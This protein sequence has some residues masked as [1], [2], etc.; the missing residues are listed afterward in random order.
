[1]EEFSRMQEKYQQL[2]QEAKDAM[3]NMRQFRQQAEVKSKEVE[4]C[5]KKLGQLERD[6]QMNSLTLA[7]L[8]ANEKEQERKLL[9]ARN[10]IGL[11]PVDRHKW[12]GTPRS[13]AQTRLMIM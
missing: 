4:E 6:S 5:Q 11:V 3:S 7:S 1:M 12:C 10:E 8:E 9:E 13:S 2:K